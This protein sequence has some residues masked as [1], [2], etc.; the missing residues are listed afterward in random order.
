LMSAIRQSGA[1]HFEQRISNPK[2]LRKRSDHR[3]CLE[4][5]FGLS[6]SADAAGGVVRA[7]TT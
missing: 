3:I 1:W 5:F 2:T 6:C 7:G 4:V